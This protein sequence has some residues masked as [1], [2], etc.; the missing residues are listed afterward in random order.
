MQA[1]TNSWQFWA[2]LAAVFAAMT[3][4]FA[5]IGVEN[6]NSNFATFLLPALRC[7]LSGFLTGIVGVGANRNP[8]D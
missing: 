7:R 5:K 1:Y 4:I 2:L 3:A 8:G 6:V